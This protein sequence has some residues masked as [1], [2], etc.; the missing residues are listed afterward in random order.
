MNDNFHEA[1]YVPVPVHIGSPADE[2]AAE[3]ASSPRS[4]HQAMGISS[5]V[6][7]TAELPVADVYNEDQGRDTM[8]SGHLSP[9]REFNLLRR[10]SKSEE[11]PMPDVSSQKLIPPW[12]CSQN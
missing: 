10:K 3:L 7:E 2:C 9:L 12:Y 11:L 5:N 8:S 4:E 6:Q 1:V